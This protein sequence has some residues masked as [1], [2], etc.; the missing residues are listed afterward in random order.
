[1][2]K[3]QITIN[4]HIIPELYLKR[5]TN[6]EGRLETLN[7]ELKKIVKSQSIGSVCSDKFFYAVKTGKF[8]QISQD[9]ESVLEKIE[10]AFSISLPEVEKKVLSNSKIIH[11][12]KFLLS[13]FMT[14]LWVRSEKMRNNFSKM[15]SKFGKL[16]LETVSV[17]KIETYLSDQENNLSQ[18][19]VQGIYKFIHEKKF[20]LNVDNMPHIKFMFEEIF[21][22]SNLFLGKKWTII[23]NHTNQ[24]FV[25]SSNPVKEIFP[26]KRGFFGRD[27]YSRDHIF[28]LTPRILIHL[29]SP[30]GGDKVKRKNIYQLD[31][32]KIIAY[33]MLIANNEDKMV[34]SPEKKNL[35]TLLTEAKGPSSQMEKEYSSLVSA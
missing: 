11:D 6:E 5:F 15:Y 22:F 30:I 24:Q 16:M 23:I 28:S 4:Q 13:L 3:A 7:I 2:S 20:D 25:T 26:Q 33:N 32:Y 21:T 14:L 34:F 8:D 29:S 9:I 17:N 1:M 35:E 27:I 18:K 12:D 10:T 19:E 31:L